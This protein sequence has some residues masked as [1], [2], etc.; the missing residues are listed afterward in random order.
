MRSIAVLAFAAFV[1]LAQAAFL[2]ADKGTVIYRD[3]DSFEDCVKDVSTI[4]DDIQVIIPLIKEG[5]IKR[6]LEVIREIA[7]TVTKA[8]EEC[9]HIETSEIIDYIIAHMTERQKICL[10]K[11]KEIQPELAE[12]FTDLDITFQRV[13]EIVVDLKERSRDIAETCMGA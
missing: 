9:A 4:Q 3:V 13:M 8:K 2:V 7:M 5:K 1:A 12:L 6:L 11:I 10:A